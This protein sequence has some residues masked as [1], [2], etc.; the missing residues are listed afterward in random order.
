M[1]KIWE[2]DRLYTFLRHY[3]DTCTRASYRRM[4]VRG[5]IPEE[6]TVL[7]CPNHTNTL[8]DALVVLR[9]R[10][11]PTVFGARA[12]I[13]SQPAVARIMRFLKILPIVRRR[14]GIRNVLRNYETMEEVQDVLANNTPFC[15]F[16]EGHHTP[17]RELQPLQKGVARMAFQS[18]AV[19]P[20]QVVPVGI[21]YSDFYHYRGSCELVYGDPIDVNAFLA[22][23]QDQPEG[24][25][26][27]SFLAELSAR[28]SALIALEV[29]SA[30]LPLWLRILLFPLWLVSAA[31]SLPMWLP[32]EVLCAR[33]VKDRAFHNTVR[34]GFRLLM[35]PITFIIWTV[36][37][38]CLLPWWQALILLALF[39]PSY[40][41]FYDL[42]IWK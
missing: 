21:N 20:T 38:F 32:A 31:L 29:P 30:R 5:N 1:R 12:D 7:I 6:N 10:K 39:V 23:H 9:S 26:Y 15:M 2:R 17:G 14:D 37:G 40:S 33:K 18:A 41:L 27:Q 3:V 28:M 25:Q 13:F 36:L 8:M 11:A 4:R 24:V 22:A 16:P 19:R 42:G 34:Y 35:G